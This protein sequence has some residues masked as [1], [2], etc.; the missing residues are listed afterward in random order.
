[1]TKAGYANVDYM[2]GDRFDFPGH[3]PFD[4]VFG[5]Y[6]L[7]HQADPAAM[8]RDAARV[9]RPGGV[10]AFHE[11]LLDPR[12]ST[13]SIPPVTSFAAIAD[14]VGTAYRSNLTSPNVADQFVAVFGA[15]GLPAPTII[16]ECLAGNWQSPIVNWAISSY[17]SLQ[18][19]AAQN[20]QI[21]LSG[22]PQDLLLKVQADLRAV[23]AQVMSRP[24]VCAW[25]VRGTG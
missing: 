21:E 18:R 23:N 20:P 11:L 24:Q 13:C 10:I 15:A 25:A 2:V 7:V 8:L 9:V 6:V 1:M 4:A 19:F 3:A 17:A 14:A 16:W 12:A 22:E 5:R